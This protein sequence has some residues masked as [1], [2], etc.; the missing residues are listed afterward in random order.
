MAK[1]IVKGYHD[2]FYPPYPT[3]WTM[4]WRKNLIWQLFRFIVLN[5]KMMRIV[6][7]GHS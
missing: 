3:K 1:N 2:Q 5:L 7:G 6:A 4:Y